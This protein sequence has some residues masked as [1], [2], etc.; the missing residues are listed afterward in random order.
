MSDNWVT[1]HLIDG[2]EIHVDRYSVVAL[3]PYTQTFQPACV[4][5]TAGGPQ[6]VVREHISEVKELI[7]LND[8]PE[9][10]CR[11]VDDR[12]Q[13]LQQISRQADTI[14]SQGK[15]IEYWQKK[16]DTA[17]KHAEELW[18][19][20]YWA[21]IHENK[22]NGDVSDLVKKLNE[23]TEALARVT[24]ERDLLRANSRSHY[25]K[26]TQEFDPKNSGLC[27][28]AKWPGTKE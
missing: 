17:A 16:H 22:L 6:Y 4:V 18:N 2:Q 21:K 19:E 25:F 1:L 28:Y 12:A 26:I 7:G 23:A 20:V 13:L 10:Q 24:Q 9:P 14:F 27:D 15:T 3:A 5:T 8:D 11:L